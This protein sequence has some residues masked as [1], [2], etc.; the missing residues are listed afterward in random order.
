M[1]IVAIVAIGWTRI[2]SGKL[3]RK[4]DVEFCGNFTFE[5]SVIFTEP[6]ARPSHGRLMG[7]QVEFW[8]KT[9]LSRKTVQRYVNET[10]F[11]KFFLGKV[12]K[13]CNLE[14]FGGKNDDLLERTCSLICFA[15]LERIALC[16][17]SSDIVNK[18]F[19]KLTN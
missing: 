11:C 14:D 16:P 4:S 9:C 7:G 19:N 15:V 13:K 18:I 5:V 3:P 2:Q 17:V 8:R 12:L 10:G 1:A 6:V